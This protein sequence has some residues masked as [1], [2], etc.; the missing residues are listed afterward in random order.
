MSEEKGVAFIAGPLF[1]KG[2]GSWRERVLDVALVVQLCV[3]L[4]EKTLGSEPLD[5]LA[6]LLA[7]VYMVALACCSGTTFWIGGMSI[8]PS[9]PDVGVVFRTGV[10][11]VGTGIVMLVVGSFKTG[12][13]FFAVLVALLFFVAVS[14]LI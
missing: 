2:L 9:V 4:L 6:G 3:V 13:Y 14:P 11:C 1:R 12:D 8:P 10:G 7:S 5:W